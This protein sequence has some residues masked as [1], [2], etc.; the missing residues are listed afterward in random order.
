MAFTKIETCL[1]CE[2]ARPELRNKHI[3]IGFFGMAPYK[4]ITIGDFKLPVSLCFV[5]CGGAGR[6]GRHTI[7]I[8]LSD[9]NGKVISN[10]QNA[11]DVAGPIIARTYTNLFMGFHGSVTVPGEY[12]VTL[13]VDGKKHYSTTLDLLAA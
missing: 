7:G 9:P 3:L 13:I 5:F 6:A 12:Q 10:P 11:P 2:A 1:I 4:Q 8:R